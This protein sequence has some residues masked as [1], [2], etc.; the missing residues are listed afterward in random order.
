MSLATERRVAKLET[1]LTPTELVL[2]WLAEAHAFDNFIA[3]T[4]S[5]IVAAAPEFPMDR[6]AREAQAS[7]QLR[8]Q[9]LPREQAERAV[10]HAIVGT[11]FRVQLVLRINVVA[12]E[13]LDREVLVQAALSAYLGLA[14]APSDEKRMDKGPIGVASIRDV[15]FARVNEL[16]AMEAARVA[17]E[18]RYLDARPALFPAALRA[19]TEQQTASERLAVMALRLAELDGAAPPADD[20]SA[21]FDARVAQLVADHVEPARSKAYDELGDGRR[22]MNVALRWLRPKVLGGD[23]RQATVAELDRVSMRPNTQ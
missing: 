19:W 5:L 2:R 9:K 10:R 18:E 12:Q 13:A 3:Y 8:N 17:V 15:A 4:N 16:H 1:Q 22:A 20:D 11:V 14:I 21:A 6:L 23:P 7:A